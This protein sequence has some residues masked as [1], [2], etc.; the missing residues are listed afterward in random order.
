[1]STLHCFC[2]GE[3]LR[4]PERKTSSNGNPFVSA[5]LRVDTDM[6]LS[7]TAFDTTVA[8]R[9]ASLRKGAA[10]ACS[11]RLSAKPYTDRD[12]NLRPGL[13]VV[14]TELMSGTMPPTKAAPRTRSQRPAPAAA[15][16]EPFDDP[17]PPF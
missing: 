8:D 9:L 4:D 12:G 14:V 2:S 3:L 15:G 5:L 10:L 7:L 16:G 17:L 1:M 13:S 11:G 6:V